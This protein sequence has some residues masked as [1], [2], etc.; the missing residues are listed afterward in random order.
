MKPFLIHYFALL[1]DPT[2][3]GN[4]CTANEVT[5]AMCKVVKGEKANGYVPV[6]GTEAARQAIAKR[7]RNRFSVKYSSDVRVITR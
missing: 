4:L 2:V 3:F 6:I 5:E 7:Y 1:G